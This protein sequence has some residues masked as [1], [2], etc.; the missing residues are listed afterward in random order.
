VRSPRW[1]VLLTVTLLGASLSFASGCA[2]G[3]QTR[4][5]IP[6][7]QWQARLPTTKSPIAELAYG[8]GGSGT[9]AWQGEDALAS[10]GIAG[11]DAVQQPSA[12]AKAVAVHKR[13]ARPHG[14]PLLTAAAAPVESASVATEPAPT[15]PEAT[16]ASPAPLLASNDADVQSRYAER[17]RASE[18]QQKF[19]GGDAIII[20]AG[21]LLVV[22]L[23]VILVLLLR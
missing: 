7:G 19:R 3:S 21:A 11:I 15:T 10:A 8:R 22:L 6:A 16:P 5:G 23:I 17:E 18:P 4:H 14:S 2:T 1:H 13:A 9:A 12:A 20:S